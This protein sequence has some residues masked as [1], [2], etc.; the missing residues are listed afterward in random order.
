MSRKIQRWVAT[1][2][3]ATSRDSGVTLRFVPALA[4]GF[5]GVMLEGR[6]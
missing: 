2:A 3:R 4:P 6:F 5:Q 1:S